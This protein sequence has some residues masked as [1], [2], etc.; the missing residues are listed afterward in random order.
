MI[1]IKFFLKTISNIWWEFNTFHKI[2][3][4]LHPCFMGSLSY[5]LPYAFA[6]IIAIPFLVLVRQFVYTYIKL[7]EKEMKA[8]GMKSA[9]GNRFQAFERM[10][11]FL[12][13][14]KPVAL[15]DRF[16]KN[17]KPHE[18]LFLAEK[19]IKE[20]YDYNASQ[21]VYISSVNWENISRGKEKLIKLLHS[22]YEGLGEQ[23]SLEDYKTIFLLNYI[24]E[25][26]FVNDILEELK[27]ELLII[28]YNI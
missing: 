15:F 27:K 12:D 22:T 11:L 23:A 6:L 24:Q 4:L 19:A 10:T 20:E 1:Q 21:Q 25:N 13:R 28:N 5:Y 3:V 26:E 18:F 16:D 14:I 7:K 9:G 17:L 2:L 8:L